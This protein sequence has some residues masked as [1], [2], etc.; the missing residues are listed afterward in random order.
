VPAVVVNANNIAALL[1]T[2]AL[3]PRIRE[4]E[5]QHFVKAR[6]VRKIFDDETGGR[7]ILEIIGRHLYQ[8]AHRFRVKLFSGQK[9][10]YI[11]HT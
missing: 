10:W 3:L 7:H 8:F 5:R 4:A 1:P 11:L 9:S 2:F 6:T